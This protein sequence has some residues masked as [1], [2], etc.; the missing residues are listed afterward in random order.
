MS[1]VEKGDG[2][3]CAD[4][5]ISQHLCLSRFFR[6][7]VTDGGSQLEEECYTSIWVQ[8]FNLIFCLS[9]FVELSEGLP[10]SNDWRCPRSWA[11]DIEGY[12]FLRCN[13][14]YLFRGRTFCVR[15]LG[16]WLNLDFV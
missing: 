6:Q 3:I 13:L 16:H 8:G 15:L 11:G 10:V 4:N 9:S 12:Q 1:P 7:E 14:A 5:C 2:L